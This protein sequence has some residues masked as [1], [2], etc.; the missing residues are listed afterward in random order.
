VNASSRGTT[1]SP[2]SVGQVIDWPT[3]VG[4]EASRGRTPRF[5]TLDPIE[6]WLFIAS[7]D[8]DVIVTFRAKRR[9]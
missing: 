4:W 7:E 5:F 9:Q 8:S 3:H 2:P 6:A 1:A